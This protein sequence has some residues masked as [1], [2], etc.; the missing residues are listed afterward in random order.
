M[1]Q[2]FVDVAILG[3]FDSPEMVDSVGEGFVGLDD[4]SQFLDFSFYLD[5]LGV[6][7]HEL[8]VGLTQHFHLLY[9]DV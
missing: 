5:V 3:L 8:F 2:D 6:L 1:P 7:G 9:N 4:S